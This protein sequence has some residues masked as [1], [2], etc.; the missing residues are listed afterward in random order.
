MCIIMTKPKKAAFP[1]EDFIINCIENNRDGFSIAWNEDNQLFNFQT[2]SP[3]EALAKYKGLAARLDPDKSAMIFHARIATHGNIK[4]SNCHCWIEDDVAFA[5]NG[6]LGI[7][8]TKGRTDSQTYF[9]DIFMKIKRKYGINAAYNN[10]REIVGASRFAFLRPNGDIE[11]MGTWIPFQDVAKGTVY[12]SNNSFERRSFFRDFSFSRR[13]PDRMNSQTRSR[14]LQS[15]SNAAAKMA[16]DLD[17]ELDAELNAD[18]IYGGTGNLFPLNAYGDAL[19]R[20][21]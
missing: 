14:D 11:M 21:K 6:I 5:H 20:R 9:H 17:A 3:D 12:F 1:H 15:L 10:A 13:Y 19:L 16:E 18:D 7:P 4:L 8:A 2:L